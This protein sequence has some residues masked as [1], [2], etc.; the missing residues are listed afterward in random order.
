M[1]SRFFETALG[2]FVVL[3]FLSLAM[4]NSG[5]VMLRMAFG[6]SLLAGYV[7]LR[8]NEGKERKRLGITDSLFGLFL[9]FQIA[10]AAWGL[11]LVVSAAPSLQ[12]GLYIAAPLHWSFCV[13]FFLLGRHFYTKRSRVLNLC[14]VMG[15]S[16]VFLAFNAIP[17]LLISGKSG[18]IDEGI[19]KFF[20][21]PLYF[22]PW[23]ENYLLA[24]YSNLNL[25]GDVMAF[26]FFPLLGM[27]FYKA[28][29]ALD[30]RGAEGSGKDWSLSFLY[31]SFAVSIAVAVFLIFSR[32]TMISF[33][34]ANLFFLAPLFLKY[35]LKGHGK[36]IF[37][38]IAG[39]IFFVVWAGN[40][41]AAWKEVQTVQTEVGTQAKGSWATNVEGSRRALRIFKHEWPL[42]A[43]SDGYKAFAKRYGTPGEERHMVADVFAMSHYKQLMAEEGAGSFLYFLFLA[44]YFSEAGFALWKIRSRFKFIMGISLM[45]PAVMVLGHA[46]INYLLQRFNMSILL[47]ITMGASLG[48][49]KGGSPE[50]ARS[51]ETAGQE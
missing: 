43:G 16:G 11:W 14:L 47:Y 31:L 39:I 18:F 27:A 36:W 9:I 37:G 25:I 30:S 1:K 46:A 45:S 13:G 35:G 6:A 10:R 3:F 34:G 32:G 50:R 17:P 21:A 7:L 20:W 8:I 29:H 51:E 2:V 22:H 40:F 42:G 38:A 19:N 48:V 4:D 44:A 23:V 24:R 15:V 41:K 5:H 28:F 33:L 12:E 49:L 26:G